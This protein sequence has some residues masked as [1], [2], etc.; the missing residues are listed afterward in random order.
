MHKVP[1][2]R[3]L[4]PG[5]RVQPVV[6][7]PERATRWFEGDNELLDEITNDSPQFRAWPVNRR[8]NNA[9]NE[10]DELI[11]ADGDEYSPD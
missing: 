3:L 7:Q 5:T 8:V 4:N 9:R 10:G 1:A 11:V 6:V 2:L